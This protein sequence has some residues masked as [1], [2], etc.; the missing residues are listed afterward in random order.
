[1]S[2]TQKSNATH[3]NSDALEFTICMC[4]N[5]HLTYCAIFP[6]RP[7]ESI[8]GD[9]DSSIYPV[10]DPVVVDDEE[11]KKKKKKKIWMNQI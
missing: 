4:I 5:S 2:N 8:D 6:N 10:Y 11:Q 3:T 1:M 9:R 7:G